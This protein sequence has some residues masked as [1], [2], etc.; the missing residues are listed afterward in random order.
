MLWHKIPF[1]SIEI[2]PDCMIE[3]KAF[4]G[5]IQND[6][7]ALK[8]EQRSFKPLPVIRQVDSSLIQSNYLQIKLDVESLVIAELERMM[9]D[10]ALSH[11]LVLKKT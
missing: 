6:H 4:H 9:Q 7:K 10:P 8:S 3:L 5:R 1:S 11:L 2:D